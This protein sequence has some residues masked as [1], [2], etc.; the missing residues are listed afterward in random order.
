MGEEMGKGDDVDESVGPGAAYMQFVLMEGIIE[1]LKLLDYEKLFCQELG[2]KPF[3]RHYF[4]IPTNPGEQFYNFTSL[5]A[6]LLRLCGKNFDP[7]QE[8]DD[9][10]ATISSILLEL[11]SLG[12]NV[13]FPPSKLKTGCGEQC[14][15]VVNKLCD[16]VLVN[17]GFTWARPVYPEEEDDVEDNAIDDE[18]E[19][20]LNKVEE[21]MADDFDDEFGEE[22][23]LLDLNALKNQKHDSTSKPENIMVSNTTAA[24]W[25]LELERVL[26]QLKVTIRTDNKDW[27]QH[28]EQMH[29]H[30]EGIEK[31]LSE[32]KTLLNRLHEEITKTLDKI[33]T[34][35]KYLNGQLEHHLNE[36]RGMQDQLAEIKERYKQASGGVTDRTKTLAEITEDLERIK[37]EMEERGSSMTDG[38]PLVKIKKRY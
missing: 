15:D 17:R 25:K 32:T 11:K 13:N 37:S 38:A 6:W 27:R 30:S 34:R 21:E 1:K 35:E 14:I 3:S 12:Q 28:V 16:S 9:P 18:A 19:L 4:A 24:E 26:P 5:C 2:F 36:F 22:E 20:D 7:P 31:S 29:S 23:S 33:A 8:Y 10:N